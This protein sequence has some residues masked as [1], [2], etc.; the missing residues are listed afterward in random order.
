MLSCILD[1]KLVLVKCKSRND[2]SSFSGDEASGVDW[3]DSLLCDEL[4]YLCTECPGLNSPRLVI[5]NSILF[6]DW[7]GA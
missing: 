6:F 1:I 4:F 3:V 2:V 5:R 7:V